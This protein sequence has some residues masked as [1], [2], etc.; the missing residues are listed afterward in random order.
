VHLW[1]RLRGFFICLFVF[2]F[3]WGLPCNLLQLS[4][5]IASV[6]GSKKDEEEGVGGS[7]YFCS[8]AFTGNPAKICR[9]Y[10]CCSFHALILRDNFRCRCFGMYFVQD[11]TLDG[12]LF[13]LS[14]TSSFYCF[15]ILFKC[16]LVRWVSCYCFLFFGFCFFYTGFWRYLFVQL[17]W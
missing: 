17:G 1:G 4:A 6:V 11:K 14:T 15:K 7:S 2:G 12:V 3:K 10:S 13:Q 8:W 9:W 5:R 16:Y